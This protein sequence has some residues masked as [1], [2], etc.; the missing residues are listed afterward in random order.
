MNARVP[1]LDRIKGFCLL[2]V[3]VNHAA[4]QTFGGPHLANPQAHWA[5]LQERVSQVAPLAG[6]GLW[7]LP[8]NLFRWFGWAGDQGVAFFIL[9]SGFG[10]TWGLMQRD[11]P[12][13]LPVG[14]FL[15]T[16][17]LRL[18]PAYWLAHVPFFALFLVTGYGL[19]LYYF[20]PAWWY[21]GLAVQLYLLFPLLWW[22]LR[23]RGVRTL[24]WVGVCL[25]LVVRGV[26]LLTTEAWLDLWSRGGIALSRL[27]ELVAGMLLA[28]AWHTRADATQAF[29][30]RGRVRAL[31]AILYVI[32]V[33]ASATLV[34]MTAAPLLMLVGL[35]PFLFMVFGH[36]PEHPRDG[37]AW[38]GRHTYA[39]FLVHHPILLKLM[40]AGAPM[41]AL[42]PLSVFARTAAGFGAT[43]V[44]GV[45]LEWVT[46]RVEAMGGRLG[47]RRVVFSMAAA[48]GVFALGLLAAE[49]AVRRF[50]PQEVEGW[51][52]R[53]S[54]RPDE[55]FGWT[56]A[57][58]RETRLRWQ[59]YD[60]TVRANSLGFPGPEP[61]EVRTPG[62]LR[63]MTFGD[64]FTSAEGVDTEAAWP[65]LL[66]ARLRLAPARA[67][68]PPVSPPVGPPVS[69]PVGPPVSPPVGAATGSAEVQNFAVTGYGPRQFAAL[70][71][72]FLPRMRPDVLLVTF[73]VND[74][75]DTETTD[76]EFRDEIGFGRPLPEGPGS[77]F[78]LAFLQRFVEL[79][80]QDRWNAFR[81]AE[82]VF[83]YGLGHFD[84]LLVREPA[85]DAAQQIRVRTAYATIAEAARDVGARVLVL[86]IP[87]G[88]QVCAR[89]ALAYFPPAV[90][91]KASKFD[92]DRPR[93]LV[94]PLI[95]EAGFEPMDL[96]PGLSALPECPYH[97][98]NM[99]WL[100][101]G[102]VAV[103]EA[104]AARLQP[105][106]TS[107]PAQ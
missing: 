59:N 38:L 22:V 71:R 27:P 87:S 7:D 66:E 83:G 93:K 61:V 50:A 29:L 3:F 34:G 14:V 30:R 21:V 12:A 46:A 16:R 20:S 100:P 23:A 80:L 19:S 24:V 26:V 8:L 49:L 31:A 104:V 41:A 96:Q 95:R 47:A 9:L 72:V 74:F 67:Q 5:P 89:E 64:A 57:P 103:A 90:D 75:A 101:A 60:Y 1:W 35:F 86:L 2:W 18:Y 28:H 43:L 4:E 98:E 97:P 73:F 6:H 33:L 17:L 94:L 11:A 10:L 77:V 56:L 105:S 92:V 102:H 69:P 42:V 39:L 40:P 84:K 32:G 78:R 25:P 37:F 45:G 58:G 13:R 88:P 68:S 85:F 36:H 44:A 107:G 63:V 76:A 15:R 65:R 62:T 81:G 82:R 79:R 99:H 70:A 51:G 54:L 55:T 48:G 91:L 52:E 53:A 106:G